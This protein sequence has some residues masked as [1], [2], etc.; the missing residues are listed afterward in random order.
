MA[1][2]LTG[3]G[4]V[5]AA[6]LVLMSAL[7]AY[8]IRYGRRRGHDTVTLS[9]TV[10][11]LTATVYTGARVG[12]FASTSLWAKQFWLT[13]VYVGLG[14]FPVALWC[15]VLAYS[16][17]EELVTARTAAVLSVVPA[18]ALVLAATNWYHGLVWTE[19]ELVMTDAGHVYLERAFTP[20]FYVAFLYKSALMLLSVVLLAKAVLT[21]HAIYRR[22]SLAITAGVA[23]PVLLGHLFAFDATPLLER[24]V[25]LTPVGFSA[26]AVF[27]SY[28]VF[29]TRLL[30]LAPVARQVAWH[31]VDD[32]IVVLND[33]DEVVDV[34]V[35][36]RRLFD[37]DEAFVGRPVDAVFDPV[38]ADD[39]LDA[40]DGHEEPVRVQ[41]GG[42]ERILTVSISEIDPNR[43]G[44]IVLIRDVTSLKRREME[45]DALRQVQ[46]RVLR[47][48]IRT[49]LTLVRGYATQLAD[50]DDDHLRNVLESTE[51]LLDISRKAQLVEEVVE[52]GARRVSHDLGRVARDAAATLED[53]GLAVEV[54]DRTG[55]NCAVEA[56]PKLALAVE[57]LLEN[58]LVHT[59]ADEPRARVT[60]ESAPATE[61]RPAGCSLTVADDG[62]GIPDQE[63][64][65]LA[66]G[67]ESDLV[68]GSGIGLWLV[69]WIV[70]R[71]GGDLDFE[72]GP[73]G[74][75]VT[76]TFQRSSGD[77]SDRTGT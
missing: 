32:A 66:E 28:A 69:K 47:H 11:L 61:R 9:F 7:S 57:N 71:S 5:F 45:L 14:G 68:H 72:T 35:A 58:A 76:M 2:Q 37:V 46:S 33:R 62:P 54:T 38:S 26:T 59:D 30:D 64:A 10:L 18:V 41:L 15:F 25:D 31:E 36:A 1:V 23:I 70:D 49:E 43:A 65:V 39:V 4:V 29:K 50:P 67:A 60:I 63:V 55:G 77:D 51:R 27:L 3:Y 74:T 16:G 6:A 34:N 22:Q 52:S 56:S 8:A 44:R 48:N 21:T 13:V 75:A 42:E 73:D 17:R 19:P 12:Q 40:A 20:M 53:Q 24:N